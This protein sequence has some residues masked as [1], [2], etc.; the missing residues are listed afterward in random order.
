VSAELAEA[1]PIQQMA[2]VTLSAEEAAAKKKA[3]AAAKRA[4]KEEEKARRA[5][6][7]AAVV[8][9][10]AAAKQAEEQAAL[11]AAAA[12]A[13][14]LKSAAVVVDTNKKGVDLKKHVDGMGATAPSAAALTAE[15]L[16]RGGDTTAWASHD[17]YG[18]ALKALCGDDAS[19]QGAVVAEVQR[20]CHSKSFPK[21]KDGKKL[22]AQHF[23]ALFI[24]EVVDNDGFDYW[25]ESED[26]SI[27]GKTT[28][29]FQST[30]FIALIN[31]VESE[32]EREEED[33]EEPDEI[34]APMQTI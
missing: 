7:A 13:T 1:A 33:M 21:D 11:D 28:A 26:E 23:Q 14:L 34:D 24:G 31:E 6:E 18:A 20:Y 3:D 22:I 4:R 25:L 27:P 29:L 8:A 30:E 5:E 9:A 10:K 19:K 15:V 16:R 12:L 32:E 17:E 2:K